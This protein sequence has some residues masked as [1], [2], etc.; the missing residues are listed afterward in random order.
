MRR[1]GIAPL[2]ALINLA[3]KSLDSRTACSK[4]LPREQNS[5]TMAKFETQMRARRMNKI[6]KRAERFA[7]KFLQNLANA[8]SQVLPAGFQNK[9]FLE[10]CHIN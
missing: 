4:P 7:I 10:S 5:A 3:S 9:H 8:V 2:N 6:F 1:C